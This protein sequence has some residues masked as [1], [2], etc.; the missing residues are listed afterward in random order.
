LTAHDANHFGPDYSG[1]WM[2]CDLCQKAT[3]IFPANT[4]AEARAQVAKQGW[5]YTE[6]MGDRCASC[7]RT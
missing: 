6:V 3:P 2:T 1:F 5:K 4:K 7:P